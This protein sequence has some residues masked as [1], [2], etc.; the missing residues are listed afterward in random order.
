[1]GAWKLVNSMN[2]KLDFGGQRSRAL[3]FSVSSLPI[4][5]LRYSLNILWRHKTLTISVMQTCESGRI[6]AAS[7]RA[8]VLATRPYV[9]FLP[10]P[11]VFCSI[12]T[13]NS[14]L[15]ASRMLAGDHTEPNGEKPHGQMLALKRLKKND[16]ERC[17]AMSAVVTYARLI[18]RMQT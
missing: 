3:T 7:S 10:S 12:C 14:A 6:E 18:L 11:P 9:Q 1:M 13:N 17:R 2:K 5:L 8:V 4:E 15:H 16:V